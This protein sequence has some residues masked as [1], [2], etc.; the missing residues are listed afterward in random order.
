M[1]IGIDG[2]ARKVVGVRLGVDGL[3]RKV[4]KGYVGV[5]GAARLFWDDTVNGP[6]FLRPFPDSRV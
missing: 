3:A 5:D 1:I 2:A 4:V 6:N